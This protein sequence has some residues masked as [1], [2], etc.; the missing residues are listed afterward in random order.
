VKEQAPLQY[1]TR[2][3]NEGY[4]A[5]IFDPALLAKAPANPDDWKI[6]K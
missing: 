2:L 5:L 3:T 6:Q 4:A 1:A